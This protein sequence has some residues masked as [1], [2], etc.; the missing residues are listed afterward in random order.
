MKILFLHLSDLHFRNSADINKTAVDE[1]SKALMPRCIGSVNKI[2]VLVTG[3]IV[4]SGKKPEYSAFVEFKALLIAG[5]KEKVLPEVFVDVF[6]VPGNHDI[7]YAE[8]ST[9]DDRGHYEG[10][11]K[12]AK[13]TKIDFNKEV[14]ARKAFYDFA[15]QSGTFGQMERM[16]C[17]KVIDIDGFTVEINL[18]NTSFFSLLHENDQGLHYMPPETISKISSPTGAMMAIALMH[19]SHQ[20]L[21]DGCKREAEKAL[22]EKNTMIFCGHEHYSAT[23]EIAY[24]G[25][26]PARVFCG[27]SLCNMGD[28]SDSEFFAC[29]YDTDQE[30]FTQYQFRWEK[31]SEIYCRSQV[32]EGYLAYKHSTDC[33]KRQNRKHIDALIEDRSI[34]ISEKLSDYYVFPGLRHEAVD[35]DDKENEIQTLEQFYKRIEEDRRIEISGGDSSGKSALLKMVFQ[36]FLPRKYVLLCKVEDISSGNRR[37]I[38]KSIFEYIYGSDGAD[39]AKFEQADKDN[40]IILIDDIHLI[41]SQ[42]INGFLEGIEDEFGYVI[43]TTNN[44]LKLDIQE[45]IKMA[46]AKD[47][48]SCYRILP[49]YRAK[50]KELVEKIIPL[51]YSNHSEKERGDQVERICHALD[52]QRRYIPLSPE[53]ILQFIEHY[54]NYQMESAQN[55]GNIFGKV[56]ES[57]ITSTLSPHMSGTLTVDKAMLVLGKIGFYIHTKRKY[58]ISDKDIIAVIDDYCEEY[59]A[60]IDAVNFIA[61]V[62]KAGILTKYE[63][64]GAYKFCNNNYLAYFIASEICAN[65]DREAVQYCLEYS[66]FGINSTV[67]MF[68]TYLANETSL[69]DTILTAATSVSEEWKEFSFGMPE[70]KHLEVRSP[71]KRLTPPSKY[72]ADR[73]RQIDDEKD[74]AEI[75][76]SQVDVVS[77]YDY[78]EE[79]IEKLENQL[80]RSI[81]LLMLIARCLPNFEHRLKK[82]Q[83]Q[84]VIRAIYELPNKIFYAWAIETERQKDALIQMILQMET[85]EFTR[86]ICTEDD[87]KRY[88]QRNSV[89]LLLELYYGTISNA[90]RENTYEYLTGMAA[91]T[92]KFDSETYALEKL[93]VLL[94]SK[95]FA[96]FY[97]EGKKVLKDTTSPAAELALYYIVQ[98]LLMK[99]TLSPSQAKRIESTFFMDKG[100]AAH[101][102]RRQIEN[103]DK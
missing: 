37:R 9:A 22:L 18:L 87:A 72:E 50:R 76:N 103:K 1:I 47:S 99:E 5:L 38:I 39:Y 27:G 73:E 55:D 102:Y 75:D 44:L 71:I 74:R 68:I 41:K 46:I 48:Y 95:R 30:R 96:S 28:W 32:E 98:R 4:Y 52:L 90:Y 61:T 91:E 83:K 6:F 97:N 100:H 7:D 89:S 70:L 81:S 21:Y 94:Q 20:W 31:N 10:W 92:V 34:H 85:N 64:R 69:I 8:L 86:K 84:A 60:K 42:H 15:Q 40:K 35:Q 13:E 67:L 79:E 26:A 25:G 63:E 56:F 101:L 49:L 11:L 17:R 54:A 12:P 88:L 33:P 2:I 93:I 3:D 66:C 23:Q 62:T 43:Y 16:F 51:K 57:T 78:K 36:Y 24:N 77:I 82:A 80:I 53:I 19:H 59:G 14:A 45:R 65:K 58:P 29:V